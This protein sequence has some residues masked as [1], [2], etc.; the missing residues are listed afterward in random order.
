MIK[1]FGKIFIGIIIG[2]IFV[3]LVWYL[4]QGWSAAPDAEADVPIIKEDLLS[5]SAID[6]AKEKSSV[7]EYPITVKS[8]DIGQANPF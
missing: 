6:Q 2:V 5:N 7:I 4:I 8:R 3:S 1:K